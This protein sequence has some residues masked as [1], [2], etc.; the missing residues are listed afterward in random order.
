MITGQGGKRSLVKKS[1]DS[2][3]SRVAMALGLSR[4]QP[5]DFFR[6]DVAQAQVLFE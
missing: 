2:L 4:L 3:E 6:I 1:R 5:E